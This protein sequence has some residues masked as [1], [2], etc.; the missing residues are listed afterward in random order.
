MKSGEKSLLAVVLV[1][2]ATASETFYLSNSWLMLEE[3][4]NK[5]PTKDLGQ[6]LFCWSLPLRIYL[7]SHCLGG[8]VPSI[9]WFCKIEQFRAEQICNPWLIFRTSDCLNNRLIVRTNDNFFV[10][11]PLFLIRSAHCF[12]ALIA[13][14]SAWNSSVLTATYC[15]IYPSL[16]WWANITTAK[17][18]VCWRSSYD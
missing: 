11:M 15:Y 9:W 3:T 7:P 2:S 6:P 1:F 10:L 14:T 16:V 12:I 4:F 13:V 8:L 17:K 18:S 5:D